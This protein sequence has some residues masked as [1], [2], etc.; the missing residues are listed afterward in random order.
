VHKRSI[1]A[2][3]RCLSVRPS[4]R[5]S[6]PFVYFVETSKHILKLFSLS[7]RST[8]PLFPYQTLWQYFDGYP[9]NGGVEYTGGMKKSRF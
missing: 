8:I 2:V 9:A 3:V 1:Y 4:V 5:P 6:V 7:S